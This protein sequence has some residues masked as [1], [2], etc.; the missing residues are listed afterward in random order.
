[1]VRFD[2]IDFRKEMFCAFR[3]AT[4]VILYNILKLTYDLHNFWRIKWHS[5]LE[6][7]PS[8]LLIFL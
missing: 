2:A 3:I 6:V 4:F 8:Q 1:M 7:S 5:T